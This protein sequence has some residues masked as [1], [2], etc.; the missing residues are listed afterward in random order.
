MVKGIDVQGRWLLKDGKIWIPRGVGLGAFTPAPWYQ[1]PQP[2]AR[3]GFAGAA[4]N[5]GPEL[6]DAAKTWHV[7]SIR[8]LV[9]QPG[10]DPKSSIHSRRYVTSL[11]A[12][13]N[14]C[15]KKG[16]VVTIAMQDQKHSGETDIKPLPTEQTVRAWDEIGPHFANNP[17]VMFELFNESGLVANQ[18]P[19]LNLK[20]WMQGGAHRHP[21]GKMRTYIGHQTM[22]KAF[23]KRGWKNV[24][25]VDTMPW[26]RR[27]DRRMLAIKDPLK[28][29]AFAVHP[30]SKMGGTTPA[31][32]D[33]GF[34]N[35]A[36]DVVVLVNEWF[37]NSKAPFSVQTYDLPEISDRFLGYLRDKRI[38][39]WAFAFD[40]PSTIVQNHKGTPNNWR[41]FGLDN[42]RLGQAGAGCGKQVQ[43]HFRIL[44]ESSAV[45]H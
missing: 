45:K 3:F 30:Y 12:G 38:P 42:V 2:D 35:A 27:I 1:N 23:R 39:L 16:F 33:A 31:Q 15:L 9:S 10:L 40:I 44:A 5:F 28:R 19:K 8:F 13:V 17:Y 21:D 11:I 36:K 14:L 25:V 22:V 7:D 43:E 34:G 4:A 20:L 18:N 41:R 32:W 37:S 6:L 29:L 26:A 24:I